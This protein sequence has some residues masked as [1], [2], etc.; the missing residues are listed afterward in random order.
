MPTSKGLVFD[1]KRFAIH[2]GAGLRTTIFF[3]GCP[4]RCK[5]CQN[6]EGLKSKKQPIYFE[7]HCIH[8]QLCQKASQL[9]EVVYQND[10]P[11]FKQG[12][13]MDPIIQACP[14]DAIRYDAREYTLEEIMEEIKKDEVFFRQRGGVTIS[15]G[16][17]FLQFDFVIELLKACKKAGIHTA[18]ESSFYTSKE[19]V[20]GV[21][22]YLDQIFCDLKE[23]DPAKHIEFTQVDN[24]PILENIRR[25][26]ESD[27]KEQVIIRTPLIPGYNGTKENIAAISRFLASI[28]PEVQYELLNYNPLASAKYAFYDFDYEIKEPIQPFTRAEM[29]EFRAVARQNGIKNIVTD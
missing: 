25:L 7:N 11:Y 28:Y 5:W 20:N 27:K 12:A 4:L 18:I 2:D 19:K 26:L 1:I 14:A 10:R 21:L 3:K 6:P 13:N 24:Q 22:P 15:G 29:N 23:M 9:G 16:E 17:P 8:C